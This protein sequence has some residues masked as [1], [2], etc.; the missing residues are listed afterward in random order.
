MCQARFGYWF[1]MIRRKK[2]ASTKKSSENTK[3]PVSLSHTCLHTHTHTHIHTYTHTHTH[4]HTFSLSLSYAFCFLH[5]FN[6]SCILALSLSLSLLFLRLCLSLPP[7]QPF[8]LALS[9]SLQARL[10]LLPS[11]RYPLRRA[12]WASSHA[13]LMR[14]LSARAGDCL[15]RKSTPRGPLSFTRPNSVPWSRTPC[16]PGVYVLCVCVSENAIYILYERSRDCFPDYGSHLFMI[17]NITI[18][19]AEFPKDPISVTPCWRQSMTFM[20]SKRK[21]W[22]SLSHDFTQKVLTLTLS[23]TRTHTHSK[24]HIH[25]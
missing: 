5:N 11:F 24:A 10:S 23:H 21:L 3:T 1:K 7:S 4:I 2:G 19:C 22:R 18:V 20:I 25:S 13:I 14:S 8:S 6:F 12:R 9:L 17:G 16:P 15:C